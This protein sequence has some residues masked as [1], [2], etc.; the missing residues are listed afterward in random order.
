M[1][2][3]KRKLNGQFRSKRNSDRLLMLHFIGVS[4]V[5]SLPF[6][7]GFTFHESKLEW[8]SPVE[9]AY[10]QGDVQGPMLPA[11]STTVEKAV[12]DIPHTQKATSDVIVYLYEEA[13]KAGLD[14]DKIAHTI[15]CESMFYNIQSGVVKD[16]VREPSFGLAQIHLPS[17]PT[18]TVEQAL[19]PYFAVDFIINHWADNAWHGYD[20]ATDSC[21]NTINEYW[22]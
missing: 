12:Y 13:N 20:R 6:V 14:G 3:K 18:V 17:H 4:L 15:Y 2:Y 11:A 10:A 16:G 9:I 7:L 1:Q 5:A 19:D 22:N 21:T 8:N